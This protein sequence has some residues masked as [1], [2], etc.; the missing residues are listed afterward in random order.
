[1]AE[2]PT[3][4]HPDAPDKRIERATAR[5]IERRKRLLQVYAGFMAVPVLII[6]AIIVWGGRGIE[7]QRPSD[8]PV[9][10]KQ[11]PVLD[12]NLRRRVDEISLKQ[13]QTAA[14]LHTTTSLAKNVERALNTASMP[15]RPSP[16]PSEIREAWR[17]YALRIDRIEKNQ[18]TIAM[19]LKEITQ[20]I[21]S[22]ADLEKRPR[23]LPDP[24]SV[25]EGASVAVPPAPTPSAPD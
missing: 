20:R 22:S 17:E 24:T 23:R 10:I 19:Q 13:A 2:D 3:E 11:A 25:R 8:S 15:S 12:E 9:G 5:E 14:D 6:V 18:Q 16:T 4:H 1:M 21:D 7:G